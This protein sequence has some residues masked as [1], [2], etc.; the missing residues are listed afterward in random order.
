MT[1]FRLSSEAEKDLDEIKLHLTGQGGASLARRMPRDI[2]RGVDF[3]AQTPG[4]GHKREDLADEPVNFWSV[5]SD[6][7]V[8]DPAT[9]PVGVARILHGSQ[10]I[11]G[12]FQK[13][14]PRA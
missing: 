7:I 14:P 12:L 5:Y 6:L 10:D 9:K 1:R 8:Y 13:R 4:A 3:I 11:E 2:R